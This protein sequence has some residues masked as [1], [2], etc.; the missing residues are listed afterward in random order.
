MGLLLV[1][2][3]PEHALWAQETPNG[4]VQ[5]LESLGD[6][7]QEAGITVHLT[8]TGE[9]KYG[10]GLIP[11]D[12]AEYR[13]LVELSLDL[14]TGQL[15]LWKSGRFFIHA[16]NGHGRQV[17]IAPGGNSLPISDIDARDFTQVSEYGL[18]QGLLKE[19]LRL[20]VGKQNVNNYFCVNDFG[21]QFLFPSYT[22]IP[23]VPLPTF[24]APALGVS[25]LARP[26]DGVHLKAGI[27]DGAPEINSL[28]WDTIFDGRGGYFLIVEPG[29]KPAFGKNG[30][31]SGHYRV[32]L[33]YHT[34][35]VAKIRQPGSEKGNYGFY[36]MADQLVFKEAAGGGQGLGLFFQLGW[37]PENRNAVNRFIG[38]GFSYT[39]LLPGRDQDTL[40]FGLSYAGLTGQPSRPEDISLVNGELYYRAQI[41]PFLNLQPD[42]QYFSNP[43][44]GHANGWAVNLRWVVS[45]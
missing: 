39:G 21:S 6:R 28:G 37:A 33:W 17:T 40:G 29:I 23:T 24:P 26:T 25:I 41:K 31:Y 35:S 4:P 11:D 15:G 27:Y 22:L 38:G 2:T 44:T 8:Y 3:E 10:L 7:L 9:A 45:F 14:D 19:K 42:I 12:T 34:G 16:Q 20:L 18:D 5:R 43:G 1:L 36:A 30:A 32:G 13:G